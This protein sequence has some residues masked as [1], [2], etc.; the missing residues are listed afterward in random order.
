MVFAESTITF[1]EFAVKEPLPLAVIQDAVLTFLQ[2]RKDAVVFGAQAVNAYVGEPRMTQD[3]DILSDRAAE[4]AGELCQ[5]LH[6]RFRISVRIRRIKKGPGYRLYQV[7]KPKNRH[8][9][10]IRQVDELPPARRRSKILV[11]APDVLVASKVIA[12]HE[13]RGQPKSGTDWRD[14][15]LLL[16][17]FPDLKKDPG[18]VTE[19]LKALDA[20]TDTLATWKELVSQKLEADDEDG[21]Y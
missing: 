11:M 2:G 19:R 18:P 6:D 21:G 16:L 15:A 1:K 5:Y 13:R 3:V 10:D 8:L 9:A 17:A 20:G 12:L 4:L 14:L 7:R